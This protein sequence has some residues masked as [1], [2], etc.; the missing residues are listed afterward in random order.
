MAIYRM[1]DADSRKFHDWAEENDIQFEELESE[2]YL[3][4]CPECGDYEF[5]HYGHCTHCRFEI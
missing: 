4:S 1:S 2:N 5:W 3:E